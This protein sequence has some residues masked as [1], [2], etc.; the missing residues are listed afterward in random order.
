MDIRRWFAP[1]V[2]RLDRP[3]WALAVATTAAT[4]VYLTTSWM[5]VGTFVAVGGT[6]VLLAWH[7]QYDFAQGPLPTWLAAG[8][9]LSAYILVS[10]AW[11]RDPPTT[12]FIALLIAA[13]LTATLLV[14]RAAASVPLH[15][16]EHTTRSLL[17]AAI[18]GLIFALIEEASGHGLKRLLYW[19]VRAA[20]LNDGSLTFDPTTKV[21]INDYVTN[22]NMPPLA[23][24]LWPILLICD[25][26]LRGRDRTYTKAVILTAGVATIFLSRHWTSM[27]A[28]V[29]ACA[30]FGLALLRQRYLTRLLQVLWVASFVVAIPLATA[31]L[32]NDWHLDQ[33][34]KSSFRARVILWSVTAER[35]WQNPVLGVGAA[36]T[37]K[38]DHETFRQAEQPA[39]FVYARR[40]GP[41]AHNFP[42]QSLYELGIIGTLLF[43]AFGVV[44]IE[45]AGRTEQRLR[46]YLL[47]ALTTVWIMGLSSF[48]LFEAWFLGSFAMTAFAAIVGCSYRRRL[49]ADD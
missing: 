33:R 7:R 24:L 46:P 41:H 19:P 23:F 21:L 18:L 8:L 17:V 37:K 10:V 48:G 20:K 39:T 1:E 34:L 6:F 40:T 25:C 14:Q 22:W 45:A 12:L 9:L 43:A 13:L 35:F 29:A 36:S 42:L 32:A 27:A 26:Q 5:A 15:W 44:L 2:W 28:I 47:G 16:L 38:L 3:S 4:L 31:G 11:S 30:V 49:S